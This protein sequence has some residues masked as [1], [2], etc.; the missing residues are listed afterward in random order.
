MELNEERTMAICAVCG[1]KKDPSDGI[2]LTIPPK[3]HPNYE[4]IKRENMTKYG[5]VTPFICNGCRPKRQ[6]RSLFKK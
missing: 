1:G 3:G 2:I 5:E 4:A 6:S